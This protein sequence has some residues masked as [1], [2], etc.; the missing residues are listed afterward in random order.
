MASLGTI[1]VRSPASEAPRPP[2]AVRANY[3]PAVLPV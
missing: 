3:T 2:A 1:A